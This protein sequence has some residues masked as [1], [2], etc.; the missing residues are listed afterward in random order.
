ML[1]F[2]L[3]GPFPNFIDRRLQ[4]ILFRLFSLYG[5]NHLIYTGI[6]TFVLA[7]RH[8]LVV[9]EAGIREALTRNRE[10]WRTAI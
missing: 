2:R 7:S 10:E 3:L 1:L 6:L 4:F 8:A 5:T 9:K